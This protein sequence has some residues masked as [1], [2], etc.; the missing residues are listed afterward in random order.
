M[1]RK[2]KEKKPVQKE[3][4]SNEQ[5][6]INENLLNIISPMSLSHTINSVTLSENY[7]NIK[8]II[9]YPPQGE[10]G[11]LSR[12]C[13]I[14][15]TSTVLEYRPTNATNLTKVYDDQIKKLNARRDLAKDESVKQEADRQI[16]DIK[17]M[18]TKIKDTNEDIGYVNILLFPQAITQQKLE[19][20]SKNVDNIISTSIQASTRVLTHKQLRA[21]KCM[22]PYGM[23]DEIIRNNGERNMPLSTVFGGFPMASSGLNDE[24]GFYLGKTPEG[25]LIII[26]T[27]LRGGDRTNSNWLVTGLPGVGKSATIKDILL[28]EWAY[29]KKIIIIDPEKEYVGMAKKLNGDIVDCGGG[30]NGKIN[31]LQVRKAPRIEEEEE[32]LYKDEGYGISDLA[33][34]IQTVRVFIKLY[35]GKENLSS[36]KLSVLEQ[37]LIELYHD[38]G[39]QWNT[40][41]DEIPNGSFPIFSDLHNK[42]NKKLKENMEKMSEKKKELYQELCDD[43]YSLAYGA[44]SFIFN[45]YTNITTK[46]NFI[47]LDNSKLVEG[48][49]NIQRAQYYNILTWCWQQVSADRSEEIL[50]GVDEAYLMVD[51]EVPQSIAFLRNMSKRMRKYSAGLLVITHSVVDLLDP[52][53]KRFG[54][55]IIDNA[56][57]KFL[58]GTEGKNLQET[59]KLFRLTDKEEALLAG[60]Q[61]GQGILFAGSVRFHLKIDIREKYLELFGTAGGK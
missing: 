34:H 53:V 57:Y 61:R 48:D 44:D 16:K 55:A 31:V 14:E 47:I 18:I 8:T 27:W 28:K 5:S 1:T 37:E 42:I 19:S 2:N 29:G 25:K 6:D 23:P 32:E 10:Y 15:G 9:K 22:A 24:G 49:E 33:L 7:G 43:L 21:L 11:W 54:Q 41:I 4:I 50:L 46:S 51:P 26:N 35:L 45:G 59:K 30:L 40:E 52:A 56:C 58:M 20:R 39:I 17:K 36:R 3:M 12:I 60:Q 38:F 13:N